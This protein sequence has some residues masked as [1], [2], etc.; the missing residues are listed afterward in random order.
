MAPYLLTWYG[1]TDLRSSIGFEPQGPVLGALLT[2]RF[3]KV[4]ILAYTRKTNFSEE[5]LD[6]QQKTIANIKQN[7]EKMAKM[8]YLDSLAY[9]DAL[10]NTPAGHGFFKNW[11]ME[12][13]A[14]KNIEVDVQLRE[15][16]LKEL[17]DT[18][19]IY[20]SVL[21]VLNEITEEDADITFFL[22]PGTPVMAFS[23]ALAML[24][25]PKRKIRLL[26]SPDFRKG[27]QTIE[28][29]PSIIKNIQES[30]E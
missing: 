19:G 16:F 26:A 2:G 14:E 24:A 3:E 5:E 21:R 28:I 10:A 6:V 29:T 1:I 7:R 9:I 13:L 30:W 17:N 12:R 23:W 22:S 18:E 4:R 25:S 15:C 11:L 8:P 27:V 20:F